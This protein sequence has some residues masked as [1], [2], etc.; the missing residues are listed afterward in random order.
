MILMLA[1][2]NNPISPTPL[3]VALTTPESGDSFRFS[4]CTYFKTIPMILF[5]LLQSGI[6]SSN[7]ANTEFEQL[8]ATFT[9]TSCL[10]FGSDS[11]KVGQLSFSKDQDSSGCHRKAG[12][13]CHLWTFFVFAHIQTPLIHN[14]LDHFWYQHNAI[15][16]YLSC[17]ETAAHCLPQTV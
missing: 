13:L 15:D 3:C 12:P 8:L 10:I 5:I 14:Q 2:S 11:T 6:L 1:T 17:H 7:Q 4:N 16:L 9:F